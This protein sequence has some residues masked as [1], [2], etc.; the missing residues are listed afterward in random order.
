MLI[1]LISVPAETILTNP[2]WQADNQG[3]AATINALHTDVTAQGEVL[4]GTH[5]SGGRKLVQ[6]TLD[7]FSQTPVEDIRALFSAYGLEWQLLAC[8]DYEGVECYLPVQPSVYDYIQPQIEQGE[9]GMVQRPY[10]TTMI[11]KRDGQSGW[12][13]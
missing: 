6:A 8:Q 3:A 1:I 12:I 4:S 2:L 5:V 7:K 11:P 10:D 9:D 13:G